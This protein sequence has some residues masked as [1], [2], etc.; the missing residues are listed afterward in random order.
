[1]QYVLKTLWNTTWPLALCIFKLSLCARVLLRAGPW[2]AGAGAIWEPFNCAWIVPSWHFQEP[3]R[4]QEFSHS[5]DTR[6]KTSQLG[7]LTCLEWRDLYNI[8]GNRK[9]FP[10]AITN[11]VNSPI[12][13]N[14]GVSGGSIDRDVVAEINLREEKRCRPWK[15]EDSATPSS[16]GLTEH[17]LHPHPKSIFPFLP[18]FWSLP[19]FKGAWIP[20]FG[21]ELPLTLVLKPRTSEIVEIVIHSSA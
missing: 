8:V 12:I 21:A 2:W 9:I 20:I 6:S 14:V 19:S 13:F 18:S 17:G 5:I 15:E 1:M 3:P 10:K 16:P 11:V 4:F 7:K